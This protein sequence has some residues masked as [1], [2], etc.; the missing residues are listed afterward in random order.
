MAQLVSEWRAAHSRLLLIDLE[1]TLV[2]YDPLAAHEEG[3]FRPP[4]WLFTLL[5]DLAADSKNVVY[6][7]S[8]M[9]T[10]GLDRLASRLDSI[11]FVAED[12]CFV[13]H[14]GENYW[15]GLVAP[16][17]LRPVR[18]ILSYF[19]ERTPGSYIEE[20]GASMCWR[21]WNDKMGD[22]NSHE[23]QWARRQSAEVANLIHERFSHS[24]RVIPCR[25]N[26]LILPR[27]ASRVAA[28]QHII[29]QMS[30]IGS[31]P[32]PGAHS[33]S[34]QPSS[35]ST[36]SLSA[37]KPND[38]A[39]RLADQPHHPP[40]ESAYKQP[41]NHWPMPAS[42]AG[43]HSTRSS[44]PVVLHHPP[45]TPMRSHAGSISVH[46]LPHH[47]HQTHTFD[48]VLALSQDEKLLA[49]V[50][51]LDL[52]APVTCTTVDLEKSRG[53]E[54]AYFLAQKDVQEALEEMVGF[55]ARDL[56]WANR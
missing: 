46:H 27:H 7:L 10:D 5:H 21:F 40:L 43:A 24:L 54:A 19:S 22:R 8:G 13:K 50:N 16:F 17:D 55:R 9:G 2:T 15:N 47:Y 18:E 11:G 20:R 34:G 38:I 31:V 1:E 25:T 45:T 52:F 37:H 32:T 29:M 53:T 41:S 12:G 23:A 3:G 44:S 36:P 49:Y 14:A 39:Q 4:E 33:S 35:S 6:V 51:T 56:K 28:V 48:F 30:I 26:C 42:A